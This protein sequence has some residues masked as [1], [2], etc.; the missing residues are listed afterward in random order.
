VDNFSCELAGDRASEF[1]VAADVVCSQ[2][3]YHS[4]GNHIRGTIASRR[5]MQHWYLRPQRRRSAAAGW[6]DNVSDGILTLFA[7]PAD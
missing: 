1:D 5:E 2:N 4:S 7:E 6:Q 3:I